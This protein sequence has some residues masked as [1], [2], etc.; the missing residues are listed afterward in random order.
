MKRHYYILI[1]VCNLKFCFTSL[2]KLLKIKEHF[3]KSLRIHSTLIKLWFLPELLWNLKQLFA[4]NTFEGSARH[5][6]YIHPWNN[7]STIVFFKFH[8]TCTIFSLFTIYFFKSLYIWHFTIVARSTLKDNKK[9][10]NTIK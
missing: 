3:G 7:V 4:N 10:L 5:Y 8:F 1:Y 9:Q 2:I 6:I